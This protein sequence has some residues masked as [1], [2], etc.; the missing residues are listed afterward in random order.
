M[1]IIGTFLLIT[2]EARS[3]DGHA[4][5]TRPE[6]K[7][8]LARIINTVCGDLPCVVDLVCNCTADQLKPRLN[9][10]IYL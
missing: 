9:R 2:I 3:A 4:L 10:M 8:V 6:V 5:F 1:A 7:L